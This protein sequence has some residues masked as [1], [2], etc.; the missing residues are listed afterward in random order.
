MD[1]YVERPQDRGARLVIPAE[2]AKG[3]KLVLERVN[4]AFDVSYSWVHDE[5]GSV[6]GVVL[7][8]DEFRR[9]RREAGEP[10]A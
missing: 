10:L 9:L 6:V 7:D 8:A 5:D 3:I 2:T 4:Q 1:L